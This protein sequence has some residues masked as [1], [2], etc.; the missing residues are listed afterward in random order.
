[1]TDQRLA[2]ARR[3]QVSRNM[4]MAVR[5]VA[6][7]LIVMGIVVSG[8]IPMSSTVA[9]VLLALA[10]TLALTRTLRGLWAVRV[11][12]HLL[13]GWSR[14]RIGGRWG[15]REPV[16]ITGPVAD[17][18]AL[19]APAETAD[20]RAVK[21]LTS[22]GDEPLVAQA[23]ARGLSLV[24]RL[25]EL[26]VLLA[27][28]ELSGV[29]RRPVAE[30]LARTETDL[31]ALLMALGELSRAEEAQRDDLLQRLAARLEVEVGVPAGLLAPA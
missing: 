9:S 28:V 11:A 6:F 16:Q 1:M 24:D 19:V 25:D 10:G 12:R 3:R 15:G 8:L 29:L 18:A 14:R 22:E 31:E 27:D 23:R 21:V 7:S 4:R 26:K 13:G 2:L 20:R 30:E 5:G 17:Q